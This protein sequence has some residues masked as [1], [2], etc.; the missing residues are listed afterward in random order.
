MSFRGWEMFWKKAGLVCIVAAAMAIVGYAQTSKSRGHSANLQGQGTFGYLGVGVQDMTPEAVKLFGLKDT[1]G[2]IVSWVVAGE[3]GDKA[4]VH[5]HDVILELDGRKVNSRNEFSDIILGKAPGTKIN[6]TILRGSTKQNL[7]ARLT[8][9]PFGLPL[10][11]TAA[12]PGVVGPLTPEDVQ[13]AIAAANAVPAPRLGFYVM[14][15]MPQLSTFFGVHDGVLVQSVTPGTPAEKAGLKAG[16]VVTKVNGIP[17]S[18]EREII[19]IVRQ[20]GGKVVS[21]TVVRNKKQM[22]LSLEVAWNRDP[23]DRGAIN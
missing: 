3:A 22:T 8:T 21:F 4:G 15:M 6:L 9:R 17:V 12:P 23:F 7:T 14:E 20:T 2:V 1:A 5:E 19:G 16:D 18:T 13:M 10:E 11:V